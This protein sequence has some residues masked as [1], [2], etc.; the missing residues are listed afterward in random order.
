M[1]PKRIKNLEIRSATYLLP[2]DE[3]PEHIAWSIDY[4]H[5]NCYYG[6]EDDYIKDGDWYRPKDHPYGYRIHKDCF[7]HPESCFSIASF[8]YDSHEG[9]YELHFVGDRPFALDKEEREI[10]WE[11]LEYGNKE[12]NNYGE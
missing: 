11:L 4:W 3:W 7:K 1:E 5:P 9:S 8:E 6:R 10:F 2:K 12:L